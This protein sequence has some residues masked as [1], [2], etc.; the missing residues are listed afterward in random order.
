MAAAVKEALY[1]N[2]IL[3]G[4]ASYSTIEEV[5]E[6]TTGVLSDFAKTQWCKSKR[7][8]HIDTKFHFFGTRWKMGL[9]N[10]IP[11]EKLAAHNFSKPLP[12]SKAD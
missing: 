1:L 7:S 10:Y 5:F 3:E 12:L 9:I 2:Q 6:S 11:T 4:L 8:K